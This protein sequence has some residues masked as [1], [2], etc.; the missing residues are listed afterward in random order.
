[1]TTDS[2]LQAQLAHVGTAVLL[3]MVMMRLGV[4]GWIATAAAL[5]FLFFGWGRENIVFGFQVSLTGSVL[6]GL[7]LFLL[8]EGPRS[9]TRRD[10]L[11]LGVGRSF[12]LPWVSR[13]TY[14]RWPTRS[15]S[16]AAIASRSS[17]WRTPRSSTRSRAGRHWEADHSCRQSLRD[18]RLAT[19]LRGASPS[20][21]APIRCGTSPPLTTWSWP[22][23]RAPLMGQHARE[24][25]LPS[26]LR[27]SRVTRSSSQERSQ[28]RRSMVPTSRPPG[29]SRASTGRRS[30]HWPAPSMSSCAPLSVNTPASAHRPMAMPDDPATALACPLSLPFPMPHPGV[31]GAGA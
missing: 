12:P 8:A 2:V 4:R 13:A 9:V 27:C 31:G 10:W 11:A 6:C 21:T 16:I 28:W 3:R 14:T 19:P 22:R 20:P 5:A 7:A 25:A 17:P 18:G 1:M 15:R 26:P 29:P 30:G 23:H 24:P